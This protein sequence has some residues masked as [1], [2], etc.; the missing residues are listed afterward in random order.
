MYRAIPTSNKILQ[1]RWQQNEFNIHKRKL[2]EV[3]SCI[4]FKR[5]NTFG[6]LK[7]QAKREKLMERKSI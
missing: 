2:K 5:P 7:S 6:R 3:K 4:D 1:K